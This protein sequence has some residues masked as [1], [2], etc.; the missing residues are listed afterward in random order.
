MR[1]NYRFKKLMYGKNRIDFRTNKGLALGHRGGAHKRAYRI[2]DFKRKLINLY[3][4]VLSI[5]YD[6]SRTAFIALVCY[7]NGVVSYI[8]APFGVIPGTIIYSGVNASLLPG[9]VFPLKSIPVGTLVHN[10]ELIPNK[11]GTVA[12][13]AGTYCKILRKVDGNKYVIIQLCSG[14]ERAFM[15]DCLSTIGRVAN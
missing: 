9:S 3:S 12:R 5:E 7:S 14:E 11:G 13:A 4:I 15:G 8:L 2:I 1:L 6:P 10:V